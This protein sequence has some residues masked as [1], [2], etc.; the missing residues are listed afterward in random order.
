MEIS[1]EYVNP[2]PDWYYE[3]LRGYPVATA[4][5]EGS[6]TVASE[7]PQ[8]TIKGTSTCSSNSGAALYGTYAAGQ[9]NLDV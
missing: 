7:Y 2:W 6:V 9:G 5:T 8:S 4:C 1:Y 3:G